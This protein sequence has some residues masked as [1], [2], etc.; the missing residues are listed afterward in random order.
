MFDNLTDKFQNIFRK[1]KGINKISEKNIIDAVREVR[2]ALLE[3]DVHFK[4]VKE[5][6]SQIKEQAL[7]ADVL[8]SLTPAQQF[9]K[10]V[11][12]TIINFM[13]EGAEELI[14]SGTPSIIMLVGLQGSGKTT[15][16]AKL[17]NHLKKNGHRP[18]LVACD[19]HRPAAR[20]QLKKLGTQLNIPV[21]SED[22]STNAV[23]IANNSIKECLKTGCNVLLIDTAGRLHI[24]AEMMKEVRNIYDKVKPNEILF[25]ADAMSGQDAVNVSAEFNNQLPITGII[26]T[27][28]D[29]DA[30]GGAAISIKYVVKKPIK[31]VGLGEKLNELEKFHPDRMTSRILGMGDIL[32]LIEK[33]ESN[34]TE[35]EAKKLEKKM[36]K[37]KFDLEDFLKQLQQI[38]N[39]GPLDQIISMI[40]GFSQMKELKNMVPDESKLKKIEAII[41]SMTP[42]ERSNPDIINGS[43]RLRISKGSATNINDVN[44]LL[45]QFYQIQKMMKGLNKK[46]M[47]NMMQG[48]GGLPGGMPGG[49]PGGFKMP[50]GF[51]LK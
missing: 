11:N 14:I 18:M 16:C 38:K 29:G 26:L 5:L 8:K 44:A 2:I 10:I 50:G 42:E 46:N 34:I 6:V 20:D 47:S 19:V 21:Y 33:A 4:V 41:Q 17:A 43:R 28:L 31:F 51:P 24:D 39:M 13:G 48:L 25:V 9:I 12:E 15:T 27:K 45:K 3:A 35:E 37:G 7:G 23:K 36:L 30:R 40:P 49:L 32:S 22:N 1:I